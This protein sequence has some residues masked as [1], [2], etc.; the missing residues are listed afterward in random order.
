[1]PAWYPTDHQP[2][3]VTGSLRRTCVLQQKLEC[4]WEI[5][6]TSI[7]LQV[8]F[9][10]VSLW[11]CPLSWQAIAQKYVSQHLAGIHLPGSW[12]WSLLLHAGNEKAMHSA[13]STAWSSLSYLGIRSSLH[14]QDKC[15]SRHLWILPHLFSLTSIRLE[16]ISHIIRLACPEPVEQNNQRNSLLSQ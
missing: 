6:A 1:M 15:Q 10:L 13:P 12:D 9:F 2:T 16:D 4:V 3:Q 14:F 11:T 5:F 7:L 8:L